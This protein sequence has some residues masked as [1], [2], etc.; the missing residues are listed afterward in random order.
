MTLRLEEVMHRLYVS[1]INCGMA[2]F[3][4]AGWH[5]WLGDEANGKKAEIYEL[6]TAADAAKWLHEQAIKHYPRSQYAE[7]YGS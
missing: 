3:W 5:V 1:E 2:S 6:N 7:R 4:D